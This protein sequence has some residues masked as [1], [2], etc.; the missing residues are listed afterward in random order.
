MQCLFGA[1]KKQ[2]RFSYK[3]RYETTECDA[4]RRFQVQQTFGWFI[5]GAD[6][7]CKK[8][9]NHNVSQVR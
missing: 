9:S 5:R 8:E 3:H 6:D 2:S 1:R 7:W 4:L